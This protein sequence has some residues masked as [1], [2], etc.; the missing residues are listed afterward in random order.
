[1]PDESY[2]FISFVKMG[3]IAPEI[4]FST[5]TDILSREDDLF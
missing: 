1:M 4:A 2:L 5:F 3:K